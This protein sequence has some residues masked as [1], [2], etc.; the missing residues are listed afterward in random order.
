MSL[1]LQRSTDPGFFCACTQPTELHP[2]S[3]TP[4]LFFC[5]VD[6]K[7]TDL[8]AKA[9]G[10]LFWSQQWPGNTHVGNPKCYVPIW[11]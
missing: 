2:K 8:T 6:A 5:V 9:E 1:M 7:I 3:P 10:S 4:T 11:K